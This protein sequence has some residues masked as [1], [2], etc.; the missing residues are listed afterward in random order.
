[1][2]RTS[3]A[4]TYA[5]EKVGQVGQVGRMLVPQGFRATDLRCEV[6][7]VG[8]DRGARW[9]R[10]VNALPEDRQPSARRQCVCDAGASQATA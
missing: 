10:M 5:R 3:R 7:K 2:R 9:A 8:R 6:G 1:M 4:H